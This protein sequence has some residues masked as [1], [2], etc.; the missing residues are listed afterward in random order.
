MFV[1]TLEKELIEKIRPD[2]C[3]RR[4]VDNISR[5][6]LDKVQS[7]AS[8]YD[9]ISDVRLVGSV[10]KD[11]YLARPDIDVFILFKTST[12]RAV[13][14]EIGLRI[15]KQVLVNKE[16]RYA[17]HPYTH[18]MFDGYEADIVPCYKIEDTSKMMSA[19]DRTPFHTEYVIKNLKESQRDEV[20]LLKRFLKGIGA[21]G[22]EA[23]V[24]G[25]SGYLVELLILKYGTFIET[26]AA[27]ATWRSGM[28]IDLEGKGDGRFQTP[29]VF[30]DPV[31]RTRNV[32]SAL[33]IDTFSLFVHAC[34]E[35]LKGPRR[36]YFFPN[37]RDILAAEEI[38]YKLAELGHGALVVTCPRPDL[39]DDNLYP[40]ANKTLDGLSVQLRN[41]GFVVADSALSIGK[42]T[43]QLAYLIESMTLSDSKKRVGPPTTMKNAEEFLAKWQEEAVLGPYI[44]GGR[45]VAMIK[46]DNTSALDAMRKGLGLA[47]VGESFKDVQFVI[48]DSE[49]AMKNGST[50]GLSLLLDKRFSWELGGSPP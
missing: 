20:R 5:S 35:Y 19:V 29:L 42:K 1:M 3:L 7:I 24:E 36:T 43:V 13:M 32:A 4:E 11:T 14:N 17:E 45:W 38:R 48:Y 50:E 47:S 33:S 21:Y 30:I 12:D 28:S 8:D 41:E 18:G 46:R 6:L 40:Q 39:V 34:K 31:D 2:D 27:A 15:G 22:A 23:K 26:V 37:T 44:E 49:G 16:E 25:F 9:E 10:S